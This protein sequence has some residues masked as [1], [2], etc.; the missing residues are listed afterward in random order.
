MACQQISLSVLPNGKAI[1]PL[2]YSLKIRSRVG[3]GTDPELKLSVHLLE[4][5]SF[6]SLQ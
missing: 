5:S 2:Q 6:R 3:K 1:V 4:S